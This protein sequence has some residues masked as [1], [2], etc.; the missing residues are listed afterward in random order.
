MIIEFINALAPIINLLFT[1][2]M[3]LTVRQLT[4]QVDCIERRDHLIYDLDDQVKALQL[5]ERE[6]NRRIVELE[7][8][9]KRDKI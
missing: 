9:Y 2:T 7:G 8:L 3:I 4:R 5:R 6:L 1:L